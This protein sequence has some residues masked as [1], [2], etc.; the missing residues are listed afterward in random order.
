MNDKQKGLYR[1]YEVRRVDGS[2]NQG[3]KHE[4]CEWF[5]LDLTHDKFA[6]PALKAYSQ[7]CANEY[8]ILS[9]DLK[10]VIKKLE[11]SEEA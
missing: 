4:H 10:N 9:N 2:T 11:E 6:I 5:V 3:G 7:A 8:P 1:K